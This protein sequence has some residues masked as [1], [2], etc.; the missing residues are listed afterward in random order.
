MEALDIIKIVTSIATPFI[1]FYMGWLHRKIESQR[2]HNDQLNEKIH[3]LEL[4]T[5][6]H[7]TREQA[8]SLIRES[9][10]RIETKIDRL[11]HKVYG[12]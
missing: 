2:A 4:K 9:T 6:S 1:L 8:I 5:Q 7:M 11:F 12:D 3:K 10:D